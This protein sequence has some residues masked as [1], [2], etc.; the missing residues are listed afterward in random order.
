M[1]PGARDHDARRV[2]APRRRG[3]AV[4]RRALRAGPRSGRERAARGRRSEHSRGSRARPRRAGDAGRRGRAGR[5]REVVRRSKLGDARRRRRVLRRAPAGRRRDAQSRAPPR[6][7]GAERAVPGDDGRA[8][9]RRRDRIPRRHPANPRD[10]SRLPVP[11]RRTQDDQHLRGG[12][13]AP[14]RE[15]AAQDD[16]APALRHDVPRHGRHRLDPRLHGRR[17]GAAA[18][19][20]RERAARQRRLLPREAPVSPGARRDHLRAAARL[21]PLLHDGPAPR[22]P[23]AGLSGAADHDVGAGRR[24]ARGRTGQPAGHALSRGGRRQRD[25][26][27]RGLPHLR[28]PARGAPTARRRR[29]PC[30]RPE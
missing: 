13:A 27:R 4:Q 24:A 17:G 3:A 9:A 19:P 29:R 11:R 6:P 22:S 5:R 26:E 15:R 21:L 25:G 18:Y 8:Q 7:R 2:A 23:R 28:G 16:P 14:R 30:G 20:H 10:P 1:A 12:R